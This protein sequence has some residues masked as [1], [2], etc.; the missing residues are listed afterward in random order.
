MRT[1]DIC[2]YLVA[3]VLFALSALNVVAPRC[4]LLAAGLLAVTLVPLIAL[5]QAG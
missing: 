5:I 3:A 1:L 4:N 2:L